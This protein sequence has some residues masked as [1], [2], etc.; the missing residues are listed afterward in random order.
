MDL[1]NIDPVLADLLTKLKKAQSP[2]FDLNLRTVIPQIIA[3]IEGLGSNDAKEEAVSYISN[4]MPGGLRRLV[5]ATYSGEEED[6]MLSQL[7]FPEDGTLSLSDDELIAGKDREKP[8]FDIFGPDVDKQSDEYQNQLVQ[9]KE[10]VRSRTGRG[11]AK[12]LDSLDQSENKELPDT[13]ATSTE[14]IKDLESPSAPA[15]APEA[16]VQA[17]P[18][19]P[20]AAEKAPNLENPAGLVAMADNIGAGVRD[21]RIKSI[22][23][24]Q[25][26][27]MEK[28]LNAQAARK[29]DEDI[30]KQRRADRTQKI[31]DDRDAD[32]KEAW[33]RSRTGRRTGLTFD[34][35]DADTQAEMRNRYNDSREA[36]AYSDEKWDAYKKGLGVPVYDENGLVGYENS[37]KFEESMGD[38]KIR[39]N[40][41]QPN[42]AQIRER[43]N[44]AM[45]DD[46]RFEIKETGKHPFG[47]GP[48]LGTDHAREVELSKKYGGD[49][50]GLKKSA[51]DVRDNPFNK[52]NY[53][54][55]FMPA[56][57]N[58]VKPLPPTSTPVSSYEPSQ[59]MVSQDM[60]DKNNEEVNSVLDSVPFPRPKTPAPR[61]RP[62]PKNPVTTLPFSL[63]TPS[64][65]GEDAS[66]PYVYDEENKKKMQSWG[67]ARVPSLN[68]FGYNQ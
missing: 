52:V 23:A 8:N 35:L 44:N 11:A 29:I 56:D 42:R 16:A 22:P 24:F 18:N 21:P 20:G 33:A 13:P 60:L 55:A 30:A 65:K 31:F 43:K 59:K 5:T 14:K 7:G 9:A 25:R 49:M 27:N 61:P 3:H 63:D 67:M 54:E 6:S 51:R 37:K 36:G 62:K 38:Q 68:I 32:L 48:V 4:E 17:V 46:I 39:M 10:R 34:E 12:T 66:S 15:P 58:Q 28:A 57:F 64:S 50:A 40:L 26:R 41:D 47:E 53:A 1:E 45:L 19:D 2:K